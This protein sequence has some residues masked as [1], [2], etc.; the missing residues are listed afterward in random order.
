M[1]TETTTKPQGGCCH[2]FVDHGYAFD[3]GIH[4]VGKV[5]K[6]ALNSIL[7]EFIKQTNNESF[8]QPTSINQSD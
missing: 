5:A 1:K 4:Y 3:T 6:Y 7:Q 8:I 2:E